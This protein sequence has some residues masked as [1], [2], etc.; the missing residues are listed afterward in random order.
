MFLI[1]PIL[2]YEIF[3]NNNFNGRERGLHFHDALH[4]AEIV[5]IVGNRF[6]SDLRARIY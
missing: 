2:A 6:N 1:V 3:E 4:L 5:I